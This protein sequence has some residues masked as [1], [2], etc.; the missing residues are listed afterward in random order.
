MAV[1]RLNQASQIAIRDCMGAQPGEKILVIMDEY[2]HEIGTSL[3]L[4]AQKLGFEAVLLEMKSRRFN[5]EEPPLEVAQ[6]MQQFDI[7][8]CPTRCSM[9]HTEA[10]R[11]ASARGVRIATLPGITRDV[12]I[13]GLNADYFK[14]SQL[15]L[16]L[17][18]I[19]EKGRTIRV[20]SLAGTEL[21]MDITGRN[22][23]AS[24]GLFHAKGESGNLPTGETFLAPLEGTT[25]G[26]LVV[27]GSMAG[28]GCVQ[29]D[30][31]W[32]EIKDGY[33]VK[34]QGGPSAR[35]LKRLLDQHGIEARNVAEFGIGTNDKA[36]ISGVL[37][38]DE[39]VMGTVHVALGDNKSMG[40]K[41]QVSSH[42]DGVIRKPSF[43]LDNRIM[44][45]EGKLI[46]P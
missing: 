35:K 26:I 16:Q 15:C 40:G 36:K 1:N 2:E 42:L 13:R 5:G 46:L 19:L 31:I 4:Q 20:T 28:V 9:T 14:I 39:K 7:V 41:V 33:A 32:I 25:Q 12:M 6:L 34:I 22:A 10:R 45:D 44:M 27:D 3:Y 8:F 21:S 30:K 29:K 38:E 43:W 23:Y 17:K 24:K 18:A 11:S 37:L